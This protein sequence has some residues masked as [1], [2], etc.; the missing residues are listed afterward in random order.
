L[1][2]QSITEKR[3]DGSFQVRFARRIP[4]PIERVWEALTDPA[5]LR[6]WWGDADLDLVDRG[7]SRCAG[8]T[9]TRTATPPPSTAPSAS[10]TRP[11][12]SRSPPPGLHRHPRPRSPDHPHLGTRPRRRPHPAPLQNTVSGP[13]DDDTTAAGWHLHLDALAT[14]LSGGQVDIAHPDPVFEPIHRAYTERYGTP[15]D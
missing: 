7:A 1:T 15:D 14:I 10:S 9:P 5:E 6:K 3:S 11:A 13:V 4:H 8:S 12:S 2:K